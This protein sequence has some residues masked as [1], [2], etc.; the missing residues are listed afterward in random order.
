M[1]YITLAI[2]FLFIFCAAIYYFFEGLAIMQTDRAFGKIVLVVC[3]V[4][5]FY[6]PFM[7]F[8]L[9]F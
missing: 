7:Y 2:P 1:N 5:I 3:T 8:Y 4:A 9:I 6:S